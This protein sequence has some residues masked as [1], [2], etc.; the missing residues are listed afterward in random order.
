M[1]PL[2]S[3]AQRERALG[4]VTGASDAG[5][6]VVCGGHQ[7]ARPGF[8]ME[9]TLLA[10]VTPEMAVMRE[11][12]FG[13]VVAVHPF[14]DESEAVALANDTEYGLSASVWTQDAGKASRVAHALQSGVVSINSSN[15]VHVTAPFGGVKASGLGRELGMAGLDA[16]TETKSIYQAIDH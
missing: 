4:Y 12:I 14:G 7:I 5:A 9:P 15:S 3:H 10:R 13:P 6:D 2:I 8:Y 11:E 16:Y 1:G